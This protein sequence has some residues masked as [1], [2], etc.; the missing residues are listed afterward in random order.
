MRKCQLCGEVH[1]FGRRQAFRIQAATPAKLK[2]LL[3]GLSARALQRRPA[4]RKWSLQEIAVHLFDVELAYGFRYRKILAEPGSL[5]TPFDQNRWADGLDYRHQNLRAVLDAFAALRRAHLAL[6]AGL[7]A[8]QWRRA[9][10]HPEYRGR[11]VLEPAFIHLAAH[12]LNHLHQARALRR[13][14]RA[15]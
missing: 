11:Y 3:R 2:R 4:P 7:S 8:Q 6:L 12:D 14:W 1:A 5:I 9:A 10:R 13:R 15:R